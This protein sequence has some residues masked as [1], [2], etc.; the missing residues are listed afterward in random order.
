M[1]FTPS[2][3]YLEEKYRKE[4]EYKISKNTGTRQFLKIKLAFQFDMMIRNEIKNPRMDEKNIRG[5]NVNDFG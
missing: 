2:G 3:R 5:I 4:A 1:W